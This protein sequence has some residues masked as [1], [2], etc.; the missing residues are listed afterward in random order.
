MFYQGMVNLRGCYH[1]LFPA[2]DSGDG[3]NSKPEQDY[4]QLR[5][6]VSLRARRCFLA[7]AVIDN[8]LLLGVSGVRS[9]PWRVVVRETEGRLDL[10]RVAG[11]WSDKK[12]ASAAGLPHLP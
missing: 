2:H 5:F 7:P 9:P 4:L 6:L 12:S 1:V 3:W 10:W 8:Q 11:R